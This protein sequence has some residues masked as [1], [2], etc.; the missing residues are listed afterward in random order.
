MHLIAVKV[1]KHFAASCIKLVHSQLGNGDADALVALQN[2]AP[3]NIEENLEIFD[4]RGSPFEKE[5]L[6]AYDGAPYQEWVNQDQ[7]PMALRRAY[8]GFGPSPSLS[9][10]GG[11]VEN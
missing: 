6:I 11:D 3:R 7:V 4:D 5:Y 1:Q 8:H 2:S 9:L 10:E